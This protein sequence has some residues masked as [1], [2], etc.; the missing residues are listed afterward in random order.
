MGFDPVSLMVIGTA[1]GAAGKIQQGQVAAQEGA[2][3]QKLSQYNA[4]LQE[5][6]A[7]AIEAKTAIDQKKQ[8]EEADRGMSTMRA[9]LGA[10]GA[11]MTAGSPLLIQAKQASENEL[12]N[13]GIGQEG[14]L[15]AGRAR[16]QGA[17]DLYEGKMAALRGKNARTG[18]Y[19]S[20]GSTL[21]TGFSKSGFF[22]AKTSAASGGVWS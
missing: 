12:T 20:A 18:S 7:Q 13:L 1:M 4:A 14:A 19:L 11:V 22:D 6:E 15:A 2:A 21:L 5:R 10:S 17:I 8:A 9:G 3:S 16:S